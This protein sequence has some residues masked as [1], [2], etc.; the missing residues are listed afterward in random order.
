MILYFPESKDQID[1]NGYNNACRLFRKALSFYISDH[2]K[3]CD[4]RAYCNLP[5]YHNP[6]EL[7]SGLPL[8]VY[9]MYESTKL[10]SSWVNFLNK[11]ADVIAVPS[12]FSKNVFMA[13]GVRKPIG[14]LSLG[15]DP[16]E[17]HPA[18]KE[19]KDGDYI[20]LWQGIAYDPNGRKGVDIAVRAFKELRA[21]GLLSDA[22]LFLKYRPS[23][24]VIIDGVESPSGITYIQGEFTRERMH[25]LY[26]SVDCCLN[27]TRGEGFGLIPLEQMAMGKPVILTGFSMPYIE[28]DCC[29]PIDYKLEKSP[30]SWNHKFVSIS[31]NGIVYNLGGLAKEIH[32]LPK[33]LTMKADGNRVESYPVRSIGEQEAFFAK[34][35]NVLLPI[36][37]R[38]GLYSNPKWKSIT[39]FQENPGK[40]A[41]VNVQDLKT[42]MLWCYNNRHAAE[43]MGYRAREYVLKNWTLERMKKE[44]TSNILP[45]LKEHL[46][47]RNS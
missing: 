11:H 5:W 31:K 9:S 2:L 46:N 20:Y 27:P 23:G 34:I 29:L 39:L 44:F 10:P 14:I 13:S 6:K 15:I 32:W 12:E 8:F 25:N 33:M 35:N 17:M 19:N 7:K 41:T 40:D 21:D 1:Y 4:F 47:G 37:K 28:H 38:L 16:L 24:G 26:S 3:G 43:L 18:F 22:R 42:K 45:L 36:Q 30:I